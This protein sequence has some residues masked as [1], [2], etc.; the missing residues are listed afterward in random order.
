MKWVS[1]VLERLW[2]LA[3]LGVMTVAVILVCDA[4]RGLMRKA[5]L[6]D[7]L[8]CVVYRDTGTTVSDCYPRAGVS[9]EFPPPTFYVVE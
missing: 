9:A 2:D 1:I 4:N 6:D 8:D 3:L 5:S 7:G